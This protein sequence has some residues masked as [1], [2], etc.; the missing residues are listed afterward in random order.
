LE[1]GKYLVL[2]IGIFLKGID[3]FL[4]VFVRMTGLFVVSPIFGRRN[5]P[6]YLKIGFSFLLALITIN[7]IAAPELDYYNSIYQYVFLILREFLVGLT[8]GYVSYLVFSS[9]YLAGQLIDMQIGFGMVNVFD[10]LSNIQVP[11]T[12]NFYYI[13]SM[14]FFLI[15]NGH[16]TLIRALFDSYKHVPLGRAS[17]N[18]YLMDDIIRIFGNLFIVG[19]KI[20]APITAAMLI[21]EVALGVISKTIPQINVFVV[22]MPLKIFLGIVVMLVA[23]PMFVILLE[24]LFNDMG[25]EMLD[26]MR[27]MGYK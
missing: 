26:F 12:S 24:T 3:I 21:T 4:L 10:P 14:L 8:L 13:M 6:A 5:I 11:I 1:G 17:F 16:H 7:I 9:I 27:D 25:S 22:G 2:P 23:V 19:F 18:N 20:A 15:M